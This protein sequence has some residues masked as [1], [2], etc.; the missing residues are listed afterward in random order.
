MGHVPRK[1]SAVFLGKTGAT[2]AGTVT[3]SRQYSHGLPQGG[4]EVMKF[5]GCKVMVNKAK[6]VLLDMKRPVP[7]SMSVPVR[8]CCAGTGGSDVNSSSSSNPSLIQ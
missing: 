2:I 1:R 8:V 4:M 5:A 6:S 7:L 3:G